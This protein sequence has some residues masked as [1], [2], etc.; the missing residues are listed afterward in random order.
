M[1]GALSFLEGTWSC[2]VFYKACNLL[3]KKQLSRINRVNNVIDCT[4]SRSRHLQLLDSWSSSWRSHE[5][6]NSCKPFA[7]TTQLANTEVGLLIVRSKFLW[8]WPLVVTQ[9]FVWWLSGGGCFDL[10]PGTHVVIKNYW[11]T[12]KQRN[13]SPFN[14]DMSRKNAGLIYTAFH[15]SKWGSSKSLVVMFLPRGVGTRICLSFD[16][17]FKVVA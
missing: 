8:E 7:Y 5:A 10:G 11:I 12:E 16:K 13:Y 15:L 9:C 3:E 4:A 6:A 14:Q 2:D 17:V 1:P